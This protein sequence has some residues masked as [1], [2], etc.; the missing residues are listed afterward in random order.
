MCASALLVKG[1]YA[2]MPWLCW[3][4]RK[5]MMVIRYSSR[6]CGIKSTDFIGPAEGISMSINRAACFAEGFVKKQLISRKIMK[7]TRQ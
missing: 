6:D 1:G 4:T 2:C 5:E 7:H 3:Q